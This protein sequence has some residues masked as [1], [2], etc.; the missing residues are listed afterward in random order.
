[1]DA[2]RP[3][4]CGGRAVEGVAPS[5]P[6]PQPTGR[7]D[8]PGWALP[9]GDCDRPH[10]L[11]APRE[12]W[13]SPRSVVV[14]ENP[15]LRWG[16]SGVLPRHPAVPGVPRPHAPAAG[17]R[18]HGGAVH[19]VGGPHRQGTLDRPCLRLPVR[20]MA[21]CGLQRI[22]HGPGGTPR[23]R[24]LTQR[25]PHTA[26]RDMA[27]GHALPRH[28]YSHITGTWL[29]ALLDEVDPAAGRVADTC[30]DTVGWLS[31]L[32]EPRVCFKSKSTTPCPTR[33]APYSPPTSAPPHPRRIRHRRQPWPPHVREPPHGHRHPPLPVLPQGHALSPP[34]PTRPWGPHPLLPA[35]PAPPRPLPPVACIPALPDVP[36]LAP[37]HAH[38]LGYLRPLG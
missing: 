22:H 33:A 9:R 5:I 2:C 4:Q 26:C 28:L 3:P 37:L 25:R 8:S 29:D 18:L 7:H 12:L 19:S 14:P 21:L 17:Q 24:G 32:E 13:D 36:C 1:M 31:P 30:P 6:S 10:V 27:R 38:C 20:L 34:S 23:T 16:G 35:Q 11:L 15:A